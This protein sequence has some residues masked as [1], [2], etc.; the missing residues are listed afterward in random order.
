MPVTPALLFD[1]GAARVNVPVQSGEDLKK[2][3]PLTGTRR[4]ANEEDLAFLSVAQLA[5]LLRDRKVTSRAL[6]ELALGRLK[7][8]DP[9]L[10]T[11]VTLTEER[12]LKQAAQA[13]AELK[14]GRWRGPLH[15]I[16]WGAKDI[17]AVSGY[18]TTWGALP[19]KDQYFNYDAEVVRRLDAAGAV[20]VAKLSLG[21]L[22]NND[23]WFGGQTKC[24]W[25]IETGSS[26]SSAG[27]AAAVS[28]GL[29]PFAI[30]SETRGSIVSPC[31]RNGVTGLRPTFGSVS[32]YGAM[33]LSWSMDKIGPIARSAEDCALVFA[34]IHGRDEKDL[35]TRDALFSWPPRHTLSAIRVGYRK[36]AF[37]EDYENRANNLNTPEVLRR[38]GLKLIPVNFPKLPP[39]LDLILIAEAAAAFDELTRSGAID[40]LIAPGKRNWAGTMR[41]ARFISAVEYLQANRVRTQ[42]MQEME[43]TLRDLDVVVAPSSRLDILAI[44]NLTGHPAV[45][46]PD[47]FLPLKDR[48]DSPRRTPSSI[49]FLGRLYRDDLCLGVA[50]A[51]QTA[52]YFHLQRPPV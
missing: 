8:F 3:R 24:P 2:W 33:A 14:S 51:F 47:G 39:A 52:T 36:E 26:G 1:V 48:P 31:T 25:N 10:K 34:T 42:L 28:A 19:F 9:V 20:L 49:T 50:H 41:S 37:D 13:D 45:V 12:A 44:T 15:G 30:G 27:P 46:V 16:P 38:L 6:T 29:V 7:R 18:P 40:N 32:R 23:S 11:V 21:A 4:P 43:N 5:A 17:L 35:T 22:A